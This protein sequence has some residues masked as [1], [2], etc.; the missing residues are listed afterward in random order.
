[1]QGVSIAAS[2]VSALQDAWIAIFPLPG[3]QDGCLYA[4][5]LTSKIRVDEALLS[6]M[7]P[8][9]HVFSGTISQELERLAARLGLHA[10]AYEHHEASRILR[11]PAIVEGA[12]ARIVENTDI[13]IHKAAIGVV[14]HGVVGAAL[15]RALYA[16]GASVTVVARDLVQ[17]AEAALTG[18]V[19]IDFGDFPELLPKIDILVTTVPHRLVD[20][21]ALRLLPAHA[22]GIDLASPPGCIDHEAAERLG[23]R[24]VWARGLGAVAPVTVGR[25]QWAAISGL[26]ERL[27]RERSIENSIGMR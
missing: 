17:R 9:G 16:L 26:I 10:H 7:S 13:T 6:R 27:L 4:P 3:M 2:A 12:I 25:A 11:V 20:T 24:T 21:A 23:R 18:A 8:G 19:A 5:G 22:V 15:T 1:M 14:G